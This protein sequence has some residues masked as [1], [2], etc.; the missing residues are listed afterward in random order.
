MQIGFYAVVDFF[1]YMLRFCGSRT[2]H[3]EFLKK[4]EVWSA[5]PIQRLPK[6]TK[7]D[8]P[9]I[10][11]VALIKPGI[12]PS[13][14][15]IQILSHSPGLVINVARHEPLICICNHKLSYL[16]PIKGLTCTATAC[17][18]LHASTYRGRFRT[19]GHVSV[20]RQSHPPK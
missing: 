16:G 20:L 3:N 19:D 2:L 15:Q 18:D 4:G 9:A 6:K 1:A 10:V 14:L 8:A 13:A 12:G 17:W 7:N 11:R 5:I